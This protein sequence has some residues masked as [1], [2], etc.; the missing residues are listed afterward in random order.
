MHRATLNAVLRDRNVLRWMLGA[1]EPRIPA[2]RGGWLKPAPSGRG[3]DERQ[4][5]PSPVRGVL[6]SREVACDGQVKAGLEPTPALC[7]KP[8]SIV[9][10]PVT[11]PDL[12]EDLS[13]SRVPV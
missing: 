8:I 9:A 2:L 3:V 1:E 4:A 11:A 7:G 10:Q 6:V 13:E 5:L 12:R